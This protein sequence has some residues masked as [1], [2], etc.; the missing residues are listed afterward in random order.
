MKRSCLGAAF[1]VVAGVSLNAAGDR[2]DVGA[3][4]DKA[5]AESL[6]GEQVKD[7]APRNGDSSD[8]YYSK[9]NYYG[10]SRRKSLLVRVHIAA[11]GAMDPE[12][13]LELVSASNGSTKRVDG[14]GDR[15]EMFAGGGQPGIAPRLLMLYVAKGNA[16]FTIGLS[17]FDDEVSALEKARSI[18]QKLIEHL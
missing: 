7:P 10:I 5:T 4:I 16:F 2:I 15:A 17:G 3:I 13:Q 9:C 14:I 18:A 11:D 6:L 12:K 1:A 8:G